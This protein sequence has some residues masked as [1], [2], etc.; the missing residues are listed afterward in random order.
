MEKNMSLAEM[1]TLCFDAVFR[2]LNQNVLNQAACTA[3]IKSECSYPAVV[4]N[5]QKKATTLPIKAQNPHFLAKNVG[6]LSRYDSK[7]PAVKVY[8]ERVWGLKINQNLM[9]DTEKYSLQDLMIMALNVPMAKIYS[10]YVVNYYSNGKRE[11]SPVKPITLVNQF[12][13]PPLS[14]DWKAIPLWQAKELFPDMLK[15]LSANYSLSNCN[16]LV[17]KEARSLV[18][19]LDET[20]DVYV[21]FN[22]AIQGH[23]IRT[24]ACIEMSGNL[25]AVF[26]AFAQTVRNGQYDLLC[27]DL[28]TFEQ[29]TY[30]NHEPERRKIKLM[31]GFADLPYKE[32]LQLVRKEDLAELQKLAK[33][34]VKRFSLSAKGELLDAQNIRTSYFFRDGGEEQIILAPQ[35]VFERWGKDFPS[36]FLSKLGMQR[37]YKYSCG[38]NFLLNIAGA[39]IQSNRSVELQRILA[40][41]A[42]GFAKIDGV[43]VAQLGQEILDGKLSVAEACRKY[44]KIA[45]LVEEMIETTYSCEG[46]HFSTPER[47]SK[48][49]GAYSGRIYSD[50]IIS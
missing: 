35:E 19:A 33:N 28:R 36:Q 32:A 7:A 2:L 31:I 23:Q 41:P 16:V 21:P 46:A 50:R 17:D 11:Y 15:E 8:S 14:I 25:R 47:H 22:C 12:R 45:E 30:K 3:V 13:R 27:D 1:R 10:D 4:E 18:L 26:A 34:G 49:T 20:S 6:L 42:A 5:L 9:F 40:L 38:N 24:D 39:P 43:D 37:K 44:N 29:V 48:L